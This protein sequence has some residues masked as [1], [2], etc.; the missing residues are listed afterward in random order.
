MRKHSGAGIRVYLQN[1]RVEMLSRMEPEMVT[2]FKA[3]SAVMMALL[4]DVVVK[5]FSQKA[6]LPI[7]QFVYVPTLTHC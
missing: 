6:K 7:Y 4:Q 1:L 5:E 3:S 2:R